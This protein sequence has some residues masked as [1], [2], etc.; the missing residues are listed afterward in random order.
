M[1]LNDICGRSR[2]NWPTFD[3]REREVLVGYL[4]VECKC[5]GFQ[6]AIAESNVQ[7]RR[8]STWH[9][10]CPTGCIVRK[11]R[12]EPLPLGSKG[13]ITIP[14]QQL[15]PLDIDHFGFLYPKSLAVG[16]VLGRR[17]GRNANVMDESTNWATI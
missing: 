4:T 13:S 5:D 6:A 7:S 9:D 14:K 2:C 10:L 15:L 11:K 17:A 3:K 1:L 16:A 8:D 12:T